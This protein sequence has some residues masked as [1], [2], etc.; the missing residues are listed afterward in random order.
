V[1]IMRGYVFRQNNPAVVGVDVVGGSLR[2]GITLMK[3]ESVKMTVKS[4]QHEK[5]TVPIAE[6]GMQVAAALEGVTVG[7]QIN[8]GDILYSWLDED[9]FRK[10]KD[11]KQFLKSDEIDVLKEIANMMR[12]RNPVWG[13]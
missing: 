7:R 9:D 1:E 4:I 5:E 6:R 12:A 8:E 10:L 2:A 13:V 3:N 11:L